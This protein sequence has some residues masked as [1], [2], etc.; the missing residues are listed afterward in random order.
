MAKKSRKTEKR[1]FKYTRRSKESI[2]A[3]ASQ[4]GGDYDTYIN[5]EIKFY[6]PREGKN[7]IRILPPMWKDEDGVDSE[8]YGYE[9]WCNYNVG[10]D[11][12][13]YLSLSK[14]KDEAD[15]LAEALKE[16]QLDGDNK[17][18]KALKPKMRVCIFVIDRL[19][20]EEG[21]Q[22]WAA[23][24][25]FDRDVAEL[26]ED[27]DTKEVIYIDDPYGVEDDDGRDLRFYKT[28][29]GLRTEYSPAKM[30]LLNVSPL[31][32]D[33]DL[34][35][36]WLEYVTDNPIPDCLNFYDYEHIEASF[37]GQIGRMDDD[38][39]DDGDK[40]ED[41]KPRGRGRGRGRRDK[42]EDEDSKP[43]GRG[44]GRRRSRDEE[45]DATEE[46]EEESEEEGEEESEEKE[47][48]RRGRKSSSKSRRR[49]DEEEESEE[50]GEEESEEESEE[51]EKP[52]GRRGKVSDRI[53][54]TNRRSKRG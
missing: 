24:W 53:K 14:M 30:K 16:A 6:K 54:K 37:G 31:H 39:D 43:R 4:K 1:S 47:K 26:C 21:P 11:K 5:E 48:P 27:E 28:G 13:S 20:E 44:D 38:D 9:I 41:E 2:R 19:A 42:D 23:P 33:E 51:K 49:K 40:D 25:T 18:A 34:M 8:H 7:I 32:T 52:R 22:L 36:E 10:P 50:E 35:D 29:S 15:P 45:E 12:Q 3:R 17:L 46:G